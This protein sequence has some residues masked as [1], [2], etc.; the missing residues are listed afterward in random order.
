M[1]FDRPEAC[2]ALSA[3]AGRRARAPLNSK[4]H[5]TTTAPHV[6]TMPSDWP[7]SSV[8]TATWLLAV[9]SNAH[10]EEDSCSIDQHSRDVEL[11]TE[12]GNER[13]HCP[14]TRQHPSNYLK[15]KDRFGGERGI[16]FDNEAN[17]NALKQ[18]AG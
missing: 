8:S 2:P 1:S 3:H 9:D 12:G 16:H 17:S 11:S 14:L 18:F 7:E 13:I 6:L 15:K 5:K 10:G 4:F